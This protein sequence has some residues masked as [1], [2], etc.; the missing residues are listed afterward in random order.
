MAAKKTRL[1]RGLLVAVNSQRTQYKPYSYTLSFEGYTV[2]D[3]YVELEIPADTVVEQ[4]A[5]GDDPN[6][7]YLVINLDGLK[8]ILS[9]T[10]D[11]VD[12]LDIAYKKRLGMV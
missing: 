1:I 4:T 9:V 5:V 3:V 6:A 2:P 12:E 10:A 11:A 7:G 8:A